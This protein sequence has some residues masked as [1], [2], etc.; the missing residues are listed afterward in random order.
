MGGRQAR[1]PLPA[2]TYR[3]QKNQRVGNTSRAKH[4]R[5]DRQ[6][7]EKKYLGLRCNPDGGQGRGNRGW[8][9]RLGWGDDE[10]WPLAVIHSFVDHRCRRSTKECL[11]LTASDLVELA[12]VSDYSQAT[13]CGSPPPS[14][15]AQ[16]MADFFNRIGP[17]C[18]KTPPRTLAMISEDFIARI[19]HEAL[20]PR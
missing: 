7:S 8:V 16:T 14:Y 5:D 15:N 6:G 9:N 10:P 1:R 19:A 18:V 20:Y 12:A 13:F 3:R 2:S 4:R 11:E 17:E